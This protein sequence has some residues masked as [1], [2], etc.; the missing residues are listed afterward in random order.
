MSHP[1]DQQLRVNIHL[2]ATFSNSAPVVAAPAAGDYLSHLASD[3][4]LGGAG[5]TTHVDTLSTN[6][7]PSGSGAA[8]QGYLGALGASAAAISGPGIKSYADVMASSSAIE[9]AAVAVGAGIAAA[10]APAA[11]AAT[12]DFLQS[13]YSQIVALSE[14]EVAAAGGNL[15][16][17]GNGL[18]FSAAS[19]STSMT[20]VKN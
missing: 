4:S 15:V 5:L 18:A 2:T 19:G 14:G 7:A 17:S 13:V 8:F 6:T 9:G 1:T 12:G 11:P 3:V 10:S 16:Q 20:F